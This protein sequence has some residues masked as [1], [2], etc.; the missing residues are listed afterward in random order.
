[1]TNPLGKPLFDLFS[2]PR[3]MNLLRLI[4]VVVL[5]SSAFRCRAE[6]EPVPDGEESMVIE[7]TEPGAV[8]WNYESGI[9]IIT[10]HFAVRYKGAVLTARRGRVNSGSGEVLAE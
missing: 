1:M 2:C 3:R 4:C 8:E 10:N 9:A 7:S 6:D 5:L